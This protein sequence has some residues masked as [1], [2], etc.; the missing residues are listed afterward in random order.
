MLSVTP[1]TWCSRRKNRLRIALQ[2]E[3]MARLDRAATAQA[4]G[5][6]VKG[7]NLS[8]S[9]ALTGQPLGLSGAT[10]KNERD[11]RH[12]EGLPGDGRKSPGFSLSRLPHHR[13]KRGI[14]RVHVAKAFASQAMLRPDKRGTRHCLGGQ[15]LPD[16]F[17]AG[18]IHARP[19]R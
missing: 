8:V 1:V 11:S 4:N 19:P 7:R 6:R 13:V 12:R 2:T 16:K 9:S 3:S 14:E 5:W 15:L 17:Q 18:L 10:V